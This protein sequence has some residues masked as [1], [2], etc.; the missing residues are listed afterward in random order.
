MVEALIEV[1]KQEERRF[2]HRSSVQGRNFVEVVAPFAATNPLK[3]VQ[4]LLDAIHSRISKKQAE[5]PGYKARRIDGKYHPGP[6]PVEDKML[7]NC[8]MCGAG[9]EK[10]AIKLS[11]TLDGQQLNLGNNNLI[12]VECEKHAVHILNGTHHQDYKIYQQEKEERDNAEELVKATIPLS[13]LP[14]TAIQKLIREGFDINAEVAAEVIKDLQKQIRR[15]D[16]SGVKYE[17]DLGKAREMISWAA[18]NKDDFYDQEV[19]NTATQLQHGHRVTAEQWTGFLLYYWQERDLPATGLISGIKEEIEYYAELT[20]KDPENL[21]V[22]EF[23]KVN[24]QSELKPVKLFDKAA[25][26]PITLEQALNSASLTHAQVHAIYRTVPGLTERRKH[27]NKETIKKYCGLNEFETLLDDLSAR[28]ETEKQKLA[29]ALEDGIKNPHS[30]WMIDTY[31]QIRDFFEDANKICEQNKIPLLDYALKFTYIAVT[32]G[33]K[34][35]TADE[36]FSA[37]F[38]EGRKLALAEKQGESVLGDRYSTLEEARK[39]VK[40]V[41]SRLNRLI[42][43]E[44]KFTTKNADHR[45]RE[46]IKSLGL[47]LSESETLLR[48]TLT[49]AKYGIIPTKCIHPAQD[50]TV[51]EQLLTIV[52]EALP[53]EWKKINEK[54]L[55]EVQEARKRVETFY[56]ENKVYD[57]QPHVLIF[58]REKPTIRENNYHARFVSIKEILKKDE[59]IKKFKEKEENSNYRKLTP[60]LKQKVRELATQEA[61]GITRG[62]IYNGLEDQKRIDP[63]A[64]FNTVYE[65]LDQILASENVIVTSRLAGLIN[66]FYDKYSIVK[67]KKEAAAANREQLRTAGYDLQAMTTRLTQLTK[68]NRKIRMGKIEE[69]PAS[70]SVRINS[71]ELISPEWLDQVQE[72]MKPESM[73][74]EEGY[75]LYKNPQYK[76]FDVITSILSDRRKAKEI[77]KTRPEEQSALMRWAPDYPAVKI[78]DQTLRM[79]QWYKENMPREKLDEAIKRAYAAN[80]VYLKIVAAK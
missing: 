40:K 16:F 22:K 55:Q 4:G 58:A 68:D 10:K 41:D 63:N 78:G 44:I 61:K 74:I 6:K 38:V 34:K 21:L 60:E 3:G 42:N 62:E 24:L 69:F 23:G 37:L 25:W 17:L 5:H 2:W 43:A 77:F 32:D 19:Y 59:E 27:H 64:G 50:S 15:D 14:R 31:R 29:K 46:K 49:A 8:L 26:K 65:N 76:R 79:G 71:D 51:L 11:I 52:E 47:A 9:L 35:K 67:R 53:D 7:G 48:D 72:G 20:E 18:K 28:Y 30:I 75:E 45:T 13:R 39:R 66:E 36:T 70:L 54:R 73:V 33:K 56:Q 12:G 1:V 57:A 80:Y